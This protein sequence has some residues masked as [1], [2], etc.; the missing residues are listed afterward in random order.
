N[1]KWKAKDLHLFV[2]VDGRPVTHVGLLQH[3]IS[4]GERPVKV[5][6][7]GAVVTE[8]K[9]HGKGYASHAMRYA[10][11]LMCKEWEVDFGLLFCRDPLVP[12]YECL[13]WQQLKEPVEVE[14][15]SGPIQIPVNVMVLPCRAEAWPTGHVKLNGLPW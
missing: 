13:G 11:T 12:F 5:C 6:G 7:V 8:L 9:A 2:D 14:Q 4:V 15:P 3:T 1:L 10:K